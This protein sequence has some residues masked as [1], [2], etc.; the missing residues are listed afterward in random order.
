MQPWIQCPYTLISWWQ[1]E[2]FSAAAFYGIGQ[3]LC[4]IRR[5]FEDLAKS[6]TLEPAEPRATAEGRGGGILR[7]VQNQCREIGL[8]ISVKSIDF[9]F[10]RDDVGISLPEVIELLNQTERTIRWEMEEKL[11]MFIPPER[12]SRYDSKEAFGPKVAK[13]FQSTSFDIREAGNCYAAARWTA[14]VFHLMRVL[15]T[16][17]ATFGKEFG[18]TM[19]HTN[20]APFLEQIESKIE[21]LA[22]A[23]HKTQADKDRVE[24]YS[25]AASSFMIFKGAW[26]NYTAHVRSKY[27]EEEA[28]A[29]YRN[30]C[31]FCQ[32]LAALELHE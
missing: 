16:A 28:D 20:W 24:S 6:R 29:I 10:D 19:S 11:F 12:A 22:N 30:V 31:F 2:K 9:F 32:R 27:T 5:N 14:C 13:Q 15:E 25:Q 7:S 4:E 17:L 3:Y 18:L 26:R 1:M 8:T 21:D 23:A